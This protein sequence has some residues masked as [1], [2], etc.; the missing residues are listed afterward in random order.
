MDGKDFDEIYTDIE[1]MMNELTSAY[2]SFYIFEA[3]S[4]SLAP[5]VVGDKVSEENL[6]AQLKYKLFFKATRIAH[7]FFILVTLAKFFDVDPKT[8]SIHSI[9]R[10]VSSNNSDDLRISVKDV[11]EIK[12]L[13]NKHKNIISKLRT[14]R[15]QYL[16]HNDKDREKPKITVGEIQQLF[17]IVET[18]L[19]KLALGVKSTQWGFGFIKQQAK[20]ETE[21]LIEDIKK[22]Y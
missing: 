3:L 9:K 12:K 17:D 16:A 20:R 10:A 21:S 8:I 5:N 22:F 18:I 15:N 13:L 14:Y 11:R 4:E 7:Q 1:S 19:N 2:S 6:D